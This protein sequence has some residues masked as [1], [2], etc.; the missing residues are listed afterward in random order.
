PTMKKGVD[1]V[2]TIAASVAHA[3][4]VGGLD[5]LVMQVAS[6]PVA[7]QVND[8]KLREALVAW[9]HSM[10]FPVPKFLEIQASSNC[11]GAEIKYDIQGEHHFSLEHVIDG[12]PLMPAASYVYAVWQAYAN[13][14][15]KS[16]NEV[17]VRL[18]NFV[19]HQA[20]PINEQTDEV[21]LRV[22]FGAVKSGFR[23]VEVT[24]DGELICSGAAAVINDAAP[25]VDDGEVKTEQK[26]FFS[27]TA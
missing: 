4:R 14:A 26:E 16:V 13:E 7:Q 1:S 22:S 12:K 10:H 15:R 3:F 27:Q 11:S 9:D 8:R 24:R 19:I 18:K 2:Q 25:V 5:H 6:S 21:K 20:I 23:A 17:G